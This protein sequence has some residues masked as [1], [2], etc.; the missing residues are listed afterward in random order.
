MSKKQPETGLHG[1]ALVLGFVFGSVLGG[2]I[3]LFL[4]PR[5]GSQTRQQLAETSNTLRVQL[6]EAV[7]PA[8]P[9]TESLAE[10]KAAARR[11]RTELGLDK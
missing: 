5:S 6:E 9:L 1:G 3:A 8:D 4:N 2:L 11:R 10:G 7:I